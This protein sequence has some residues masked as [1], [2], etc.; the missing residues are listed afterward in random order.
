MYVRSVDF[1]SHAHELGLRSGD[2]ILE[3]NDINVRYSTKSHVISLIESTVS[4]LCLVVVADGMSNMSSAN[5]RRKTKKD[6]VKAFYEKV[7]DLNYSL[8]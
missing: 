6:R 3:I 5:M 8:I 2:L 1:D 7:N 4:V